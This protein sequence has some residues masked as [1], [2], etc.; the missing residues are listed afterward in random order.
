MSQSHSSPK[1]YTEALPLRGT[2]L[3][4]LPGIRRI[5]ANN[6]GPMTYH[7]T[8]TYLLDTG[9]GCI[10]VDPGPDDPVHIAAIHAAT[11]GR[12]DAILLT[13]S[14]IDHVAG[15]PSLRGTIP[16]HAYFAPQEPDIAP[17]V[18]MRDGDTLAGWTAIHT[19]GHAGDHLCFARADG[20]VLSGDH[21]MGWSTTVVSP[22]HG[23]MAA[24]FASLDRMLTTGGHTY[25]P[26][27]GPAITD[28]AA[29]T[30]ALRGHRLAREAAILSALAAPMPIDALTQA[31][32]VGL[33]PNLLQAA[34]RNVLSHLQK[35]LAEGRVEQVA[36]LWR[37]IR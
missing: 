13:H 4:M 21:I 8:N 9:T 31:V 30:T 7:G 26:G 5:V 16:V 14:H 15:L 24:Y 34:Q 27:H 23:D 19:P 35:L 36:G 2:P 10:V 6:P 29:F 28:P 18:P 17:D 20:V 22:P 37:P 33:A 25:L 3:D 11:A 12:I 32:Y 1:F